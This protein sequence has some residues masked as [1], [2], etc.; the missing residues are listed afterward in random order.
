MWIFPFNVTYRTRTLLNWP[1]IYVVLYRT[2]YFGRSIPEAYG[3]LYLPR[4]GGI[5]KRKIQLYKPIQPKSIW[6][7]LNF[8]TASF[9][10]I[11]EPEKNLNID[12]N[13]AALTVEYFG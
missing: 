5:N 3:N 13:R 12:K 2:D 1:Q 7:C 9:F 10:E 4:S 11:K 6:S 8:C